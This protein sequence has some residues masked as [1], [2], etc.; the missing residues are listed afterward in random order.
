MGQDNKIVEGKVVG[1]D[2]IPYFRLPMVEIMDKIGKT[3]KVRRKQYHKLVRDVRKVYPYAKFFA[4]KMKELDSTLKTFDKESKRERYLERQ[5]KKLKKDLTAELRN[6]TYDQGHILIKLINRET[7]KT[8][9][10][11]IKRYKTGWNAMMWQSAANVFGMSLKDEY[12]KDKEEA[13]EKIL[14]ALEEVQ[15]EKTTQ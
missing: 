14:D 6:L 5:E 7:G 2:T 15:M 10:E 3:G 8:S 1:N 4:N 12:D 11:L 9:Y 13:I